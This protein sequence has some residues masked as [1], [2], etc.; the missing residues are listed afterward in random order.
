MIFIFRT[1]G[2]PKPNRAITKNARQMRKILRNTRSI[3]PPLY[4][5][6]TNLIFS[7]TNE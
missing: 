6:K 3:T 1:P 2:I 7:I 4:R 5:I